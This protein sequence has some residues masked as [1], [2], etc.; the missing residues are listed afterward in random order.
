MS[1]D[2]SRPFSIDMSRLHG[3]RPANALWRDAAESA[4]TSAVM[5]QTSHDAFSLDRREFLKLSAAALAMAGAGCS[6]APQEK[7]LPYVQLPENQ[8][9]GIPSYFATAIPLEGYAIGLLVKNE[10]GR[11]IK[12]E[13][14][15]VHP[16][17]LGATGVFAQASILQLWDPERAQAITHAN[18]VATWDAFIAELEQR[19]TRLQQ[20]GGAG[21]RLLTR[22]T[23]SPV[24]A[25]QLVRLLAR[26][27]NAR[28][29]QWK[30]LHDDHA[31]EGARLALGRPV[32]ILHR[33]ERANVVVAA[34]A[35]FL[36]EMPGHLRY[37]HD[38]MRQR[39]GNRTL[40]N[41]NRLYVM[42]STPTL[43]GA[44]ADHRRALSPTDIEASMVQ[45]A[46][47]L[48]VIGSSTA[49]QR[50]DAWLRT[51]AKDLGNNAGRCIIVAGRSLSPQ[52]HALVHLINQRLGNIGQTVDY[53][54]PVRAMPVNCT[55]S[56]G[57]L[58]DDM[59]A[60]RVDTLVILEGNPIYDAPAD[61]RF[62][63]AL[64]RVPFSVHQSLYHNET[65]AASAWH[66]PQTHYL[67]QWGDAR[68]YD[69]TASIIQP[70]IAPLYQG[71]SI[72]EL[73]GV[74]LGEQETSNFDMLRNYWRTHA[75]AADFDRFWEMALQR[76]VI[77]N[78]AA[79]LLN[80]KANPAPLSKI[81]T[82]PGGWTIR[83]AAD[84]STLDG[85]FANNAWLQELP[86]PHNKLTWDNAALISPASAHELGVATGD[87]LALRSGSRS[88][89]AP[90]WILPGQ[91]DHIITL[92]LGYGRKRA[93]RVGN[94]IGFDAYALRTADAA[95]NTPNVTVSKTGKTYAFATTQSHA[96]MEGRDLVR[97]ATL[98]EYLRQPHFA[99][100]EAS[101]QVPKESLYPDWQY[102]QY[103]W[104][105]AIDL[106]T[107]IG[108][109]A[110]TIACQAENNIPTVGK[111]QVA[112]GR[113][114]HWIRVDRYYVGSADKPRTYFQPV[115]CMHC[116]TA[117][118]EEVCPVG[119]TVHDS[120]GL[121]LQVYNRCVGTRFCSN[122]CPYKVRRFNFLQYA[123]QDIDSL[124]AAQN[125]QVTVRRRGVM[126]KCTYCL[127]RI[128]RARIDSE[129]EGRT[130]RDG[131]V[132]TACQ[133]VCPTNAIVFG[134]LN[135]PD[136]AVNLVKRSP[137]NYA[138]LAELNTRPR[139][140][141]LAR[142]RN[143]HP[144]IEED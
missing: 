42:E 110:C 60:G 76:G 68:A 86:R 80:L 58:V 24:L 7:I 108:C 89:Q 14:N 4:D 30:P 55:A 127:Q 120:E 107:C 49:P 47:L 118:C 140:T 18:A 98:A 106:N 123:N 67:E 8:V 66:I 5:E 117:P 79:P 115:P 126:E 92:P 39:A 102:P 40:K 122:N 2:H 46:A 94:G 64:R 95:W 22:P 71:K 25:D 50:D 9:S 17:S 114:M 75:A 81:T 15:P 31:D 56:L 12:A 54:S 111:D 26:Y 1:R 130:L 77:P 11:P 90:A 32:D 44:V 82:Q 121:N 109:N 139:T 69:G 29:H 62:E 133:A 113:E 59:Q 101:E 85:E 128:T 51:V 21:L 105:M 20:S 36:G 53:I 34:D 48:G 142:V 135:D 97:T 63:D 91:A 78:S 10:D 84:Y 13:G 134:D 137:L 65:S 141:Y 35:D 70:L 129:K 136:S 33:F 43:A 19:L 99:N 125:P 138:L 57:E 93:G 41:M 87:V 143:P 116:E 96:R 144:D 74:L 83:F 88:L 61:F 124:K 103:R 119:A 132:V 23:A 16:A 3:K 28:W 131:E 72:H 38:F 37:A 104:G 45:L 73:L 112:K 100:D 27:P 52:A 6:R